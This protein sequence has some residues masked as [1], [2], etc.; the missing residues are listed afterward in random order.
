MTEL[1][2]CQIERELLKEAEQI[3][4]EIGTTPGEIV[5]L[6]FTQLVKR[7][8]IPFPLTPEPPPDSLLDKTRRNLVLRD[9]DDSEGW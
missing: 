2:S 5:R 8:A 3:S 4:E 1:F 7:R 6:T 9:L